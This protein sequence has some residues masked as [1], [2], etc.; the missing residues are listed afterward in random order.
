MEKLLLGIDIGTTGAKA[1]LFDIEGNLQTIGQ[2]EYPL[3]HL[4]PGWAEQDPEDWWQAAC[5]AIKQALKN[6]PEGAQRVAGVAVSSQAPTM[7]PLDRYGKPVRPALIWMDRRAEAEA[8]QLKERFGEELI[9]TVTGNRA[10]PFYVAAKIL[11]YK[12]HEPDEFAQTHLF[13][14]VNGYINYRLTDQYSLDPVHAALLELRDWQTGEWVPELCQLC[15][16]EPRQFP[17]ILPGH[18]ILGE[19]TPHAAEA[20]GLIAGT[21]VMVGTVDGSAA[22]LEAGAVESGIAAEMTGTSTVLLMPN[23]SGVIKPV[24]IAMPHC[25]P[26]KYL[27]LGAMAASG[28]SLRWYRDRFGKLEMEAS[29]QLGVDAYDLLTLQ[30]SQIP[31]GSHGVIFLP[32]MMGE[33]SP[34]W[35]TNARGV[36]FGLSL[37]TP[38]GAIIRSILEGIAF[39]LRHNLEVAQQVGVPIHEIRSVGGGTHSTLWN[40]IK[41]DVLGLP[42][43]IPR[44]SVGAPFADAFLV[45]M[46]LGIYTDIQSTLNQMIRIKT[47][48]EPNMENQTVYTEMY[49]IFRNIYDKLREEFDRLASVNVGQSPLLLKV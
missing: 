2:A 42:I 20:T 47:R 49:G 16:V 28:A 45:G 24:F 40:Q 12:T 22:A 1:A 15:G 38:R 26:D 9:E 25:I 8:I 37:T 27:L 14:Q 10:D 32:Y 34:L 46:G 48:Y 17:P 21:P 18:H 44:T 41:A 43:L 31:P 6:I 30:A 19:I 4:H 29:S 11:W 23:D 7:L 39:A 13:V 3:R 33:R 35:H 36:F 5:V